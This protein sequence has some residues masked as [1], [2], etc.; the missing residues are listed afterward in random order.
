MY[1]Y[2]IYIISTS[3][4]RE[5]WTIEK[6]C[7]INKSVS[8]LFEKTK[9]FQWR[10]GD[11]NNHSLDSLDIPF[12]Q[13]QQDY[14]RIWFAVFVQTP[15]S[16]VMH[17]RFWA[18]G[19]VSGYCRYKS[20]RSKW[21]SLFWFELAWDTYRQDHILQFPNSRDVCLSKFVMETNSDTFFLAFLWRD[22]CTEH[23]FLNTKSR[24]FSKGGQSWAAR[25]HL[26]RSMQRLR[27]RKAQLVKSFVWSCLHM[28]A[29][30][31]RR[32]NTPKTET[33][34]VGLIRFNSQLVYVG[35]VGSKVF[36]SL[37]Y[38]KFCFLQSQVRRR[39]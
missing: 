35:S 5:M 38:L 7:K 30:S 16:D 23:L 12:F 20:R 33:P 39:T 1:I 29:Y 14:V 3:I 31:V 27:W 17:L 25:C 18:Y 36:K 21:P 13:N 37:I 6:P 34:I 15:F 19:L 32:E 10:P 11:A 2:Y 26:S 4:L 28:V 8:D 9:H 24:R 22:I